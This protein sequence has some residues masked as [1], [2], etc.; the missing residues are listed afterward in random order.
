M[1]LD[2]I[3]TRGERLPL[4]GNNLFDLVNVDG[5]TFAAASISSSSVSGA[6]GSVVNN[7]QANARSVV[8]DLRIKSSADVEDA[9]R[10]ILKVVKIKQRGS[11]E[12]TQN[13]KTV[14]LSGIVESVDMPRW[15]NA[16]TL[17]VSLYCEQPFWEDFDD[18]LVQISE[19]VNLHYFTDSADDMLYFPVE[20]IP[21]GQYDATRTK[22]FHN[23]GDVDVGME[24]SVVALDTATNPIIYDGNGNFFGVGYGD[25]ERRVV[26]QMGDV[27]TITTHKGKK[28]VTMGGVSLLSKIKPKSTWLQLAAGDNTFAINSDDSNNTNL[29]FS[30]VFRQRYV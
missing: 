19:V 17:Q 15:N 6:D 24:I 25:G 3:S 10:A 20:G 14:V 7:V 26:M 9:K 30:I 23:D 16:V 21:F 11:L 27:I 29:T 8:L 5:Q 18:V 2:Y 22:T 4:V 1:K 12:W 28:N 13:G